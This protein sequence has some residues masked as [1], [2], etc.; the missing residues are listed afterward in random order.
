MWFLRQANDLVIGFNNNEDRVT[1]DDWFLS[2]A[3]RLDEIHIEGSV[4]YAAEVERLVQAMAVFEPPAAS[5][6][7][8]YGGTVE[9]FEPV[10]AAAVRTL[11]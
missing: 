9:G 6:M 7:T 8:W 1:V 11:P 10:L 3:A 5:A 4:I 2:E